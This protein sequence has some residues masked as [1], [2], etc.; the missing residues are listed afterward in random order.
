MEVIMR[1]ESRFVAIAVFSILVGC[2]INPHPMDMTTAV[3]SA[4]T[5]SDHE[6]LAKHYEEAAKE[7]QAKAEEHKKI[8]S[9]YQANKGL[10]GKSAQDLINHCQGLIRIYEQAAAE[11]MSM[12]KE[13]RDMAAEVK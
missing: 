11:N 3:Q 10:Y 1:I 8:L 2:S 7:M 13:H 6:T 12:A 9:Q 4:K 5:A